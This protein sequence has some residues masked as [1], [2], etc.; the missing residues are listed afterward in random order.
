L[1]APRF[2]APRLVA[3]GLALLNTIFRVQRPL[4]FV[5]PRVTAPR[6][7]ALVAFCRT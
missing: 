3:L 1:A 5:N 4:A 6:F 2:T 7:A